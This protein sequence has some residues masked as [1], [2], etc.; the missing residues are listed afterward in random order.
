MQAEGY[1]TA[2]PSLW[3]LCTE[4]G[5]D[6]VGDLPVDP[7]HTLYLGVTLRIFMSMWFAKH[8]CVHLIRQLNVHIDM[9]S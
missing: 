7:M 4:G 2:V 8:V 3:R 6:L 9:I 5:F 1:S